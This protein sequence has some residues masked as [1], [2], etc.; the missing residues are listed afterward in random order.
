MGAL[1][2]RHSPHATAQRGGRGSRSR[3]R[4]VDEV[5]A[6]GEQ[7]VSLALARLDEVLAGKR[8]VSNWERWWSR[9]LAIGRKSAIPVDFHAYAI[10]GTRL[11]RL[12][13]PEPSALDALVPTVDLR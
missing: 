7:A 3:C 10:V 2:H 4:L 6:A 11:R 9:R 13:E 12:R 5:G 1:P 8:L